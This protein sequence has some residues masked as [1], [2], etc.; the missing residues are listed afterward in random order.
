MHRL[1]G[2]LNADPANDGFQYIEDLSTAYWYSEVLFTA[3]DLKLFMHLDQGVNT[4]VSL[5][6]AS[7]CRESELYRLLRGMERMALVSCTDTY[8][9][10]NRLAARYLV[11]GKKD[12]MGDF[13]LYRRYMQPH[14]SKLTDKV[15][16][17]AAKEPSPLSYRDRNFLYV[18]AM[19]TL[20]RQKAGGIASCLKGAV[21]GGPVLDIGG[22]AGSML[23]ALQNIKPGLE[24]VVLDIDE[25]LDAA[26]VLYPEESDWFG[27]RR[28][29]GDFR[30]QAMDDTYGIVVFSNFLHAYGEAEARDLLLKG[31]SLLK[32]GGLVLVHDYFPDRKGV[33]P[34]KGALYDLSM[35][36]NTFNGSCHEASL[37]MKWLQEGGISDTTIN[38]LSTDTSLIVAGGDSNLHAYDNPW[39]EAALELDFDQVTAIDPREVVTGPWVRAKCSS[40]CSGYGKNLQCPPHSMAYKETREMLDSYTTAVLVQGQPP[41]KSFH[42]KLLSLEKRMFLDGYYKAFVFGAGPC[43]VCPR[44]PDDGKCR[45]HN[46]A[47]PAMEASGMDVYATAAQVGWSLAPVKN[48]DGYV[49]YIGLLLVK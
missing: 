46:L 39:I 32:P 19:D 9:M 35:M 7:S 12:Y 5:A 8:W 47:R 13:F 20:A 2:F 40:G 26:G 29:P 38:D 24:G 18:S 6:E 11:P 41:G 31:I 49:K 37:I 45:H 22:G 33:S 1:T 27:I 16:A 4:V 15:R 23:R 28:M 25:V 43:P 34:S 3:L 48:K 10:N 44:C 30:S 36:L 14:W 42:E 21:I 17:K